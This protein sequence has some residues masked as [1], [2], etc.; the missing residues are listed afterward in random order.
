MRLAFHWSS[1]TVLVG[2]ILLAGCATPRSPAVTVQPVVCAVHH[3]DLTQRWVAA[4]YRCAETSL[5]LPLPRIR[6]LVDRHASAQGPIAG[7][8]HEMR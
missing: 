8:I 3:R 4:D 6:T 1:I 7:G 2:C 5:P